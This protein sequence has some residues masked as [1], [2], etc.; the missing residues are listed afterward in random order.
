MVS[1]RT[2]RDPLASL[3][4]RLSG[5]GKGDAFVSFHH[6]PTELAGG[7]PYAGWYP[8][9]VR[10]ISFDLTQRAAITTDHLGTATIR[11]PLPAPRSGEFRSMA[12]TADT[13]AILYL[14]GN[15]DGLYLP[16]G[17]PV[18]VCIDGVNGFRVLES[19]SGPNISGAEGVLSVGFGLMITFSTG[20]D[21]IPVLHH[22]RIPWYQRV[23]A[24]GG[25]VAVTKTQAAGTRDD[26]HILTL[27]PAYNA[28]PDA[29]NAYF[30]ESD[31]NI[32]TGTWD[33]VL[34]VNHLRQIVCQVGATTRPIIFRLQGKSAKGTDVPGNF[35]DDPS[36]GSGIVVNAGDRLTVVTDIPYSM[37]RPCFAVPSDY[38]LVASTVSFELAGRMA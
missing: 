5:D 4:P 27:A 35:S 24:G 38:G 12:I 34:R 8:A 6:W 3:D 37:I 18:Y 2:Y 11:S 36:T 10:G 26:W 19:Y 9:S 32:L 25:T 15:P 23:A 7:V 1:A 14:G 16:G 13:D 31:A 30:D 28:T 17:V 20:H 29:A 21:P 33:R 22:A